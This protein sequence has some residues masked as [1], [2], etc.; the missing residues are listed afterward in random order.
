MAER[1]ALSDPSVSLNGQPRKSLLL[2]ASLL[3]CLSSAAAGEEEPPAPEPVPGQLEV[4]ELTAVALDARLPEGVEPT[5]FRWRIVDGEGGK[6]FSADQEDAVFL[7]P[8]VDRGVKEFVLELR[9]TYADQPSSTRELK[10]RV[11]PADPAAAEDA[12]GDGTPDWLEDHYRRAR[13]AEERKQQQGPTVIGGT[14]RSGPN[15]S[16]GVA[17]GS[18]GTRG[19]VGF[20]WSLSHPLTQPVAVPPPGQSH[21]PG[22][23]SWE[24]ARPVPY[25]ELA[26]TLPPEV[27]ERYNAED[28]SSSEPPE[29]E[30]EPDRN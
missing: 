5:S 10:I 22:E 7:A 9:V 24:P 21:K 27:V 26:T 14:G 6:L 23:G 17:G 15:V 4:V 18:G 28:G 2:V 8:K 19:G 1:S 3:A 11:L 13:E 29:T 12:D 16:I 25:D 30:T 20:S